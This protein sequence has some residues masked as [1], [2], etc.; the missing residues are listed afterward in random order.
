M[1]MKPWEILISFKA[2]FIC[3]DILNL[4]TEPAMCSLPSG[5]GKMRTRCL[6]LHEE[7][8][9]LFMSCVK[10]WMT[11]INTR[12][13]SCISESALNTEPG[14]WLLDPWLCCF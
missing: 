11:S 5:D 2:V 13:R 6:T 12:V 9:V 10:L 14:L 3:G 4:L 7:V 8:C 1:N